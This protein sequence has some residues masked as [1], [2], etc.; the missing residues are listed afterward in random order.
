MTTNDKKEFQYKGPQLN[1]FLALFLWLS[2]IA[3]SIMMIVNGA[4]DNTPWL[5]VSGAVLIVVLFIGL[6]GLFTVEPNE[7][8]VMVFLATIKARSL[9]MASFGP[10]HSWHAS[11]LHCEHAT[12]TQSQLKLTTKKG[13]PYSSEW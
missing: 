1:G 4:N 8:V 9:A 3:S 7:A 10:I 6:F 5:I 13:I 12:L 2:F 11:A